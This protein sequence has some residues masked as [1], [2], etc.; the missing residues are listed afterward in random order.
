MN[1]FF[2]IPNPQKDADLKVTREA[3]C[4]LLRA[5]A[6][7]YLRLPYA[8]QL[9]DLSV[10]SLP[11]D[12]LPNDAEAIITIGG[13]GTVL[14]AS[15]TAMQ[16]GIPL[17][18]I[19][20]GR[21]GYMADVE[22]A[23]LSTLVSLLNDQF[24]LRKMMTLRVALQRQG[25]DWVL[26]RLA[27][28]DVVFYRPP[29]G[30]LVTMGLSSSTSKT[31]IKYMADGLILATPIGS[32][33]YSLSAGGPV[34]SS[35]VAAI[36]ATPVCPHSFFNRSLLYSADDTLCVRNLSEEQNI[37]VTIDGRE[38]ILLEPGDCVMVE[39]SDIPFYI[40][41][42]QKKDFISVLQQKMKSAE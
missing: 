3:A 23:Q 18:G 32:T 19:N 37:T 5:G 41:S 14:E 29:M 13:D 42:L 39:R 33:A 28:N 31:V 26:P 12:E 8:R 21:L 34:L 9:A 38:N 36:C 24:I 30:H 40:I 10:T 25:K 11:E 7:V 4:V 27:V 6:I 1:R 2:L 15:R 20:L 17:L 35:D 16:L 22:P